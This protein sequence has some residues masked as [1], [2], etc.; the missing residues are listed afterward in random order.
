MEW[1][2][3]PT[4][5]LAGEVRIPGDKSI[6]H[7]ALILGAIAD[8]ESRIRGLSSGEDVASTAGV[9]RGLGAEIGW[10]T[11]GGRVNA[12]LF[13]CGLRGLRAPSEILD[14]GNSGTTMRLM[15]G[16]LAG[17]PFG[18]VLG[19]DASLRRR[20]MERVAEPLRAMGATIGLSDRGTAPIELRGGA[21]RGV[22]YRPPVA[23]AQVKSC[24]LLAG[25]YAEGVTSV[26][27]PA[28]TRDHTERMLAAA[29]VKIEREGAAVRLQPPDRM[30]GLSGAVPGDLS[31]ACYLVAAAAV[32]AGARVTLTHVGVNPTRA[33]CLDLLEAWGA[34]IESTPVEGAWGEPVAD[35]AVG[36]SARLSGGTVDPAV[37]PIL[38]DELPLLG[39]LAPLTV[40]GIE[41]H[42][43]SEL[44]VKESDRIATTC[45]AIRALGGEVDEYPDGFAVRGGT[46]LRGGTVDAAGDHRI[47]LATAAVSVAAAGPVRVL[48]AGAA[49]VSWPGF[50]RVLAQLAGA[51]PENAPR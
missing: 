21:L 17:Q 38:I 28:Q 32:T 42:G 48:G 51:A 19:G 22:V 16:L 1:K 34:D 7:R 36:G 12:R 4:G 23:S 31:S 35:I 39:L 5:T 37:V 8:G 26:V 2:L 29:G 46:G 45:A 25:L 10:E 20:P 40:H 15:A 6:G 11:T 14:C 44:R 47:A 27:E 50:D 13:G 33:A 18:A 49:A 3:E 43:A 30:A 24:V 41:V 9:L